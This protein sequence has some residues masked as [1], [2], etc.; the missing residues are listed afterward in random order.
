VVAR[1]RGVETRSITMDEAIELW[2][3]FA[4]LVVMGCSSR[5]RS[6]RTRFEFGWQPVHTDI[7]AETENALRI[8][9]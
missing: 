9:A 1:A 4:T 6:P 7:L 5:S 2:G 3:K 8:A